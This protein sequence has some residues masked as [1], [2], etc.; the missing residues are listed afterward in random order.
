MSH[1]LGEMIGEG[2]F[3]KVYRLGEDKVVKYIHL[4]GSELLDYIEPYILS[5]LKHENI[6][7]CDQLS[8]SD[9]GLLKILMPMANPISEIDVREIKK[10]KLNMA[11]QIKDGLTFLHTYGIVHGDIKPSNILRV[12]DTYK[13]N[14]FG[15]S[16]LLRSD[17]QDIDNMPYSENY[18]PPEVCHYLISRKSDVWAFGKMLECYFTSKEMEKRGFKIYT[19]IRI[20]K[21]PSFS[22]AN[23]FMSD[24]QIVEK[25]KHLHPHLA[26]VGGE[27]GDKGWDRIFCQKI[28]NDGKKHP[29]VSKRYL[30]FENSLIKDGEMNITL[31]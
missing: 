2:S 12:G 17:P 30:K 9:C 4:V 15:L 22:L 21:R 18:R 27:G 28:R 19:N 26:R 8:I 20:E 25:N 3:G 6:M 23:N 29:S 5:K 14:D 24:Q 16:I 13:I 31:S 11:N 1:K 7:N 10:D